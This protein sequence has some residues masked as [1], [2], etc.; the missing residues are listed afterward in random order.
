[1][2]K[3]FNV[4]VHGLKTTLNENGIGD[5]FEMD[6]GEMRVNPDLFECD[7]YRLLNGDA[8]TINTYRGE[9]MNAYSWASL[10]EA[11][12]DKSIKKE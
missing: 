3:S 11:A 5:I 2:Q 8:Q 4:I 10:S 12:I 9:Y 1:M 7:M 6:S